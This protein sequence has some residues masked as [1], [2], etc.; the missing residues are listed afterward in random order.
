MAKAEAE[1]LRDLY[2]SQIRARAF[3][4]ECATEN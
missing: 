3:E 4:S 2:R 1:S